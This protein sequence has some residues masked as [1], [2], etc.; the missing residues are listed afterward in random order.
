MKKLSDLA[1]AFVYDKATTPY[2]GAEQVIKSLHSIFPNAPLFT[3]VFNKNALNW[4]KGMEIQPSFLQKLPYFK[5]HPQLLA[6]LM[7]MAF[8]SLNL[9][10]YDLIISVTSGEA[11]GV[12]TKPHQLHLCYLLTPPRYIYSHRLEYLDAQL[13]TR[14][15]ILRQI[16]HALLDY[17]RWWDQA[18]VHRPD[19]IVPISELVKSRA[20]TYYSRPSEAVLYPPVPEISESKKEIGSL[21]IS[22]FYL[23]AS[24]LV[25]YK[26]IDLAIKAALYLHKKLVIVGTGNQQKAL[27]KL[28]GKRAAVRRQDETLTKF[29]HRTTDKNILFVGKTT[30]SNLL[31]LMQHTRALLMPGIE[32]FG[33]TALQA[34]LYGKPV[35]LHQKSGAAEL[36]ENQVHG[37]HLEEE[38]ESALIAAIKKLEVTSLNSNRLIKNAQ[39]FKTQSFTTQFSKK[40]YDLFITYSKNLRKGVHESP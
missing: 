29:F 19:F 23:C 11:K 9:D 15:P 10:N 5:N 27:I 20:A 7:P 21:P 6:V 33:I 1:V 34:N 37:L 40:V 25:R 31:Q 13:I 12:I 14:L 18:A 28:A 3:S 16:A 39:R 36:I 32:D 22:E 17:L 24:R 2:G 26:R 30:N 35:I 8:E 38:S 4:A